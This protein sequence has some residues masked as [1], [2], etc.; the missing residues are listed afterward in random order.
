MRYTI[1]KS[2]CFLCAVFYLFSMSG[3]FLVRRAV[4]SAIDNKS[5]EMLRDEVTGDLV[6]EISVTKWTGTVPDGMEVKYVVVKEV[7]RDDRSRN[8]KLY[9]Y[10]EAGRITYYKDDSNAYTDEWK[11]EYNDDGTIAH[12]EYRSL[13]ANGSAPA[14]PDYDADYE[15]NDN[16]QLVSFS[17]SLDRGQKKTFEFKYENGHLV[18]TDYNDGKDYTY[19]TESEYYDYCAVVSDDIIDGYQSDVKICKRT[20]SDDTFEKVL[21]EQYEYS[22][23][24]KYFEYNGSGLTGW[25]YVDEW[26]HTVKHNAKGDSTEELDKDG[27]VIEKWEY[28]DQGD[29]IYNERYDGG[30]LHDKVKTSYTYNDSGDKQT[31]TREFWYILDGEESTF[32]ATTIYEYRLGLLVSEICEIDGRF[33]DMTVYAYK[34]IIVPK[35]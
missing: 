9:D 24:V 31:E 19:S 17:Y 28:N 32:D 29:Q 3:C 20:Y 18:H 11:L 6:N 33:T 34:A 26:G 5:A 10:D 35:E 27:S 8:I 4:D 13:K 7:Y 12:R 21:T 2:A 30:V 1:K 22:E 25:Y 16:K 15:Y 23:R 14:G